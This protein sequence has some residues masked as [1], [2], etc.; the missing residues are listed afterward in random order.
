M[1]EL[2]KQIEK[3]NKDSI[4]IQQINKEIEEIMV[5][6]AKEVGNE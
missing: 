4:E 5:N 1:K 6:F 2:Q 3:I